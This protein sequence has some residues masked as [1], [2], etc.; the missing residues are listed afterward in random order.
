M[1]SWWVTRACLAAANGS[2]GGVEVLL[3]VVWVVESHWICE[4]LPGMSPYFIL[5]FTSMD[6]DWYFAYL[7]GLGSL[8]LQNYCV[9][10]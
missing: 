7:V 4:G 10:R 9:K 6:Y 1:W 5:Y 3:V 8:M 2:G